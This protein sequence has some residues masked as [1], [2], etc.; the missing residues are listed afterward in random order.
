MQLR[1]SFVTLGVSDFARARRFY[2]ATGWRCDGTVK[3][4]ESRGFPLIEV[5]YRREVD[6]PGRR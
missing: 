4:D 3:V 1:L 5:R 6:A 2:E